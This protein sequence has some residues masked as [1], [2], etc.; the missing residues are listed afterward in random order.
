MRGTW[1]FF[2]LAGLA[3][4]SGVWL[5]A[6]VIAMVQPDGHTC[7][8]IGYARPDAWVLNVVIYPDGFVMAQHFHQNLTRY[9]GPYAKLSRAHV[10]HPVT[11]R[12]LFPRV[13]K[14]RATILPGTV[15][16]GTVFHL[17]PAILFFLLLCGHAVGWPL[18]RRRRRRKQGRCL[19]C[20]YDLRGVSS[21]ACS[22]CGLVNAYRDAAK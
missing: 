15:S 4:T 20:G 5:T 3:A 11:F 12:S 6:V 10:D 22:E 1:V 8:T 2:C 17:S 13:L 9:D 16:A 21:L 18:L 7:I 19:R 14:T